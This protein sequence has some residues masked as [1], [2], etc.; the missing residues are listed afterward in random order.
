MRITDLITTILNE[1]GEP[2]DGTGFCTRAD[3]LAGLDHYSREIA[4]DC[5][6]IMVTSPAFS[7]S[8]NGTSVTIDAAGNMLEVVNAWRNDQSNIR[9]VGIYTPD[10]IGHYDFAWRDSTRC[11][12][13]I[14]KGLISG[15]AG[16]GKFRPYPILS[17]GT[18]QVYMDYIKLP[19]ALTVEDEVT[20][21]GDSASQVSQLVLS[22]V[23][24]DFTDN[25]VLYWKLTNSGIIRT[26]GLY[27]T[28]AMAAGDLVAQGTRSNNGEIT[29]TAQN[30]SG[31]TGVV[32]VTYTA[33][34]TDASNTVTLSMLEIPAM[35]LPVLKNGVKAWLCSLERDDKNQ[36]R[37][38]MYA[39]LYTN[40]KARIKARV[41]Q[42]RAGTYTHIN[43]RVGLARSPEVANYTFPSSIT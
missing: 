36:G 28:S 17:V 1:L 26:F 42:Q 3:A 31:I 10:Q 4:Q 37:A 23:T 40:G 6:N 35:D 19:N 38:K 21:A 41:D 29:L 22:G 5:R 13:G 25:Y 43:E 34:D 39:D 32:T 20:I 8:T 9:Q 30:S 16:A 27:K 33:D 12:G 2:I 15:V 14:L 24:F 11:V 18:V 7:I